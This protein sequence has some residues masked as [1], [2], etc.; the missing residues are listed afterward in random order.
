VASLARPGGDITGLSDLHSDL[1]PKRLEFLKE[2]TPSISRIAVLWNPNVRTN[3][4][5]LKA[6][7]G[8]GPGAGPD[9]CAIEVR[10]P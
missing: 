1:G 8:C 4:F 10:Q 9:A 3:Q 6:H 2:I 7:P 5:K